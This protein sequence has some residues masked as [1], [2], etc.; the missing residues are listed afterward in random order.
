M[1]H[2]HTYHDG[3]K[4]YNCGS[5]GKSFF[6]KDHLKRHNTKECKKDYKCDY[7]EKLF[8]TKSYLKIHAKRIHDD[9]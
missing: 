2:I 4:D 7:C 8:S 1:R 9:H 5:C 6:R 3:R